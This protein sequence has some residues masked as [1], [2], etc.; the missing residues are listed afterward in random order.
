MKELTENQK[1]KAAGAPKNAEE[2]KI[3]A[4]GA[5]KNAEEKKIMRRKQ[6]E[7]TLLGST[8]SRGIGDGIAGTYVVYFSIL[9]WLP[10]FLFQIN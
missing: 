9:L 10:F 3:Q 4:A 6:L 2:K 8:Q 1:Y 7:L 5:P